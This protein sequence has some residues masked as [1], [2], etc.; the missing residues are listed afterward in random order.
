MQT[1]IKSR[2]HE[3]AP[4]FKE[5][6]VKKTSKIKKHFPQAKTLEIEIHQENNPSISEPTAVELTLSTKKQ[7]MRAESRGESFMAALEKAVYKINRQVE[8]YKDRIYHS[9]I[10]RKLQ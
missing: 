1:I 10:N 2:E 4:R 7:L 9:K 6:I 3:V 5:V 8:K